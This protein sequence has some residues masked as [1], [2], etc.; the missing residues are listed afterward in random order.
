MARILLLIV[1][2]WIL[3]H[4]FKRIIAS[5]KQASMQTKAQPAE[6]IVMCSQCG[7]HIPE[8]ESVIKDDLIYCN[9]PDC[10]NLGLK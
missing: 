4:V 8:S 3:Y 10:K 6:K 9:N 5:T 1:L 2:F 7:L